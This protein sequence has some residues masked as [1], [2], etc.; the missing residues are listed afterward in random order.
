MDFCWE[1]LIFFNISRPRLENVGKV[2]T[3]FHPS[4][5]ELNMTKIEFIVLTDL[6]VLQKNP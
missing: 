3:F 5:P 2:S 1:K 6:K 4:H